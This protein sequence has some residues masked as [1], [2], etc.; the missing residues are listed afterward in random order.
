MRNNMLEVHPNKDIFD[1]IWN[2][3]ISKEIEKYKN[4]YVGHIQ[5]IPNAK[6]AIW[7]KYVSLNLHCK[8]KYMKVI[9]GKIDRHKVAACYIIAI[10]SVKPMCLINNL[11]NDTKDIYFALNER[12]AITVGLSILRAFLVQEIS[13]NNSIDKEKKNKLINALDCG[14]YTPHKK[15][16]HHGSY[17]NNYASELHYAIDEGNI[18]IL[19]IAHELYLL[20]LLTLSH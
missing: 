6:E 1:N 19:S 13:E 11:D 10:C 4:K 9:D 2:V 5:I 15:E 8:T 16:V 3:I 20:E 14:I 12:L 17:I 18:H 7:T